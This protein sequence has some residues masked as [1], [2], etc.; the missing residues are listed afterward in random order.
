MGRT[1]IQTKECR[2]CGIEKP[3][4]DFYKEPNCPL[5][6]K[7]HC[8]DCLNDKKFERLGRERI[9]RKKR[10]NEY[11]RECIICGVTK[12]LDAFSSNSECYMGK[13]YRCKDCEAS[14][15]RKYYKTDQYKKTRKKYIQRQDPNIQY[16]HTV[17]NNALK[18]G[19]LIKPTT[20][21]VNSKYCKGRIEGHHD[22]YSKPLDVEWFCIWHHNML[23]NSKDTIWK[24]GG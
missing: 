23:P 22:D 17:V 14:R 7:A 19:K 11:E 5:G 12:P 18:S 15:R 13:E 2:T 24:N 9:F 4:T 3:L 20:C 6:V 1:R 16:S 10:G 8:K 21:Q